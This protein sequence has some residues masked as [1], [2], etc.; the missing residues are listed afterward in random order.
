MTSNRMCVLALTAASAMACFAP[1]AVAAKF[2]GSWSMVAVTTRGHCG[3]IPMG[4][5][6][7][8]GRIY[9]TGGSFAFYAIRLGG[10]VSATGNARINAVAGPRTA[11]GTGRFRHTEA[12]GM[13]KGRGPSG[14]C[15]GTWSANRS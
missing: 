2:D 15:S 10:R 9:A 5:G 8:G 11:N 7:K 1:P 3:T 12:S 13:W 14:L 6:I 4:L